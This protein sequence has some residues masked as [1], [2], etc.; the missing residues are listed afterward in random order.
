MTPED[1]AACHGRGFGEGGRPWSVG[2]FAGLLSS[3]HVFA[4]GDARSFALGRVIVGEAELLTLV[5]DPAHRRRG[6]ARATLAAFET[7]AAARDATR[8][9][10]EVA[11]DNAPALRLYRA[12]GYVE[13]AQ[14]RGYYARPSGRTV[15]AIVMQKGL[16]PPSPG[17]LRSGAAGGPGPAITKLR[18]S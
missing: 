17:D 12:A 2:E 18:S 8:A 3:P 14:R 11:S 9:F 4:V 6:L 15:D 5:T 13:R 7:D 10:L 1:M 16:G